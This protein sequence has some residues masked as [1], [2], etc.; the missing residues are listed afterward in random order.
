MRRRSRWLA[1]FLFSALGLQG[2]ARADIDRQLASYETEARAIG[3][4][5]PQPNQLTGA[6]GQRRLVDAEVAYSLGDYDT[7]AL[8]LFDLSSKPGADQQAATFYLAES[9]FQKHDRGAARSYYEQIVAAN[10]P[11]DRYYQPS[12]LRLIEIAIAMR[13][14][15]NVATHL[16][17]LD[18][19]SPGQRLPEVP[20]VRGKFA[21]FD[22]KLDEALGYFQEVPKGSEFELQAL[23][24][25]GTTH[26]AKKDLGRA[27]EVFTDLIARK[28]R[29]PNDRRVI[30][31][32][33]LAL[34]RLFYERDQPSKSIDSYL[35]VDRHSDLFPDA[36]YEVAWVYVKGKQYDK[37]L[38]ALELLAISEPNS[39]NTPTVRILEGNLRIRKAQMIRNAK[40]SGTLD[41]NF[42]DADPGLEYDKAAQVFTQ[43]HDLYMP[44]Y[45]TLAQM[46]DGGG[47]PARYL[48][49][50]A[51]RSPHVFQSAAPIPE[52]AAQYLRDEPEVQRVVRVVVDLGDVEANIAQSEAIISHLDGVLAA[53][54]RSAVYPALQSRRSR[55]G[56]IQDDL[57][58]IRSE[59]ADQQLKLV[60]GAGSLAA[61]T[62]T[63]QQLMQ[64][65][66]AMP[67][68]EQAFADRKAQAQAQY[69][70]VEQSTAEVSGIIDS[71]QAVAVALR[72]YAVDAT[73]QLPADQQT[74]VTQ[75][76]DQSATEAAAIEAELTAIQR[77]IELGRDLSGVGD[78]AMAKAQEARRQLKAAEDAEHRELAGLASSSRDRNKSQQLV[79][80]AD[81][82]TRVADSLTQT[83]AQIDSAAE[84]GMAQVK[85]ALVQERTNVTAYRTELAAYDAEVKSI[86]GSV[87]GGSFKDVK[88]KFYDIIIRTDVGNVDVSWSQKDD[89]DDDL[90]R[91]NLSRQ[92]EL[93]QLKDEFR[94]ILEGPGS[95]KPSPAKPALFEAPPSDSKAPSGSPDKGA[96]DGRVTPGT[97]TGSPTQPSVKPDSSKGSTQ[98]KGTPPKGGT[99]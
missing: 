65:Y 54:D 66:A 97:G 21:F 64:Q 68:A 46:V 57:I 92:R 95:L 56:Q 18:R 85:A 39:N 81:R 33:Q 19:M 42:K 53:G 75:T 34:G 91:L 6:A 25:T 94:D 45:T 2:A 5:L 84:R 3:T 67:N 15:S 61:L 48:D 59:L 74:A 7:A 36:L 58:K 79:G 90:K 27:T 28:P 73:P 8:M 40:I 20:Y 16:A 12:L 22:G 98:P 37:A 23:Y 49:Q 13:D 17:A 51:G 30:E 24:Y 43:T 63:R 29:T 41:A 80:L 88:A 96:S 14:T 86:G 82:A 52:A 83:E 10:N 72:K 60:D 93:K 78:E 89:S 4:D 77:E 55:I 87:L 50:I 26:V 32:S 69:D 99:R 70:T 62:A 35:L 76:L 9:L 11:A 44:S 47:D 1:S 71:T 31:L 38:R